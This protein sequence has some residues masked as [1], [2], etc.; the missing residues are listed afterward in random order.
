MSDC[1]D[2][3]NA[4]IAFCDSNQTYVQHER[5]MISKWTEN[6]NLVYDTLWRFRRA[7]AD[8]GA[9]DPMFQVA[10]AMLATIDEHAETLMAEAQALDMLTHKMIGMEF[11][12]R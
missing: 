8:I 5:R 4:V 11:G 3:F 2:L 6:I 10:N 9:F 7:L 12:E 1:V